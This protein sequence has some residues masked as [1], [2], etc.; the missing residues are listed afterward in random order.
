[1]AAP[2]DLTPYFNGFVP[3]FDLEM[4]ASTIKARE[5]WRSLPEGDSKRKELQALF[6]SGNYE[7]CL[8]LNEPVQTH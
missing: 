3:N 6:L 5:R 4:V 7:A 8:K 2:E 1:M